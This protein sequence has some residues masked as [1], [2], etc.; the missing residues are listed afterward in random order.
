MGSEFFI[1]FSNWTYWAQPNWKRISY[2]FI[3]IFAIRQK[4]YSL[5][6][7]LKAFFVKFCERTFHIVNENYSLVHA[8]RY[9][10]KLGLWILQRIYIY[11][12]QS[13]CWSNV[14]PITILL[15]LNE[16]DYFF[17]LFA[18]YVYSL[19]YMFLFQLSIQQYIFFVKHVHVD[20]MGLIFIW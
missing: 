13:N 15:N 9:L 18:F 2:D 3:D 14:C 7:D 16:Y 12:L 4:M 10:E 17:R 5:S 19:I 6:N 20:D 11:L 8:L 1:L